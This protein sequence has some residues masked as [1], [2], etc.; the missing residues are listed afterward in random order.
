MLAV[1]AEP[2][3][4]WLSAWSSWRA[5]QATSEACY[6]ASLLIWAHFPARRILCQ[7]QGCND[8][9]EAED[10]FFASLTLQS[11]CKKLTLAN[12]AVHSWHGPTF[13]KDQG[14]CNNKSCLSSVGL[15][16]KGSGSM[17]ELV[18]LEE[19]RAS[20]LQK[21]GSTM[22]LKLDEVA[23]CFLQSKQTQPQRRARTG[24]TGWT[25]HMQQRSQE[26]LW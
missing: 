11:L 16:I 22:L 10:R 7:K 26:G 5:S 15:P 9:E 24:R 2:P 17:S 12:A 13:F 21:G 25:N 23:H 19:A 4:S 8:Q 1:D 6:H 14:V 18:F 3:V 20:K